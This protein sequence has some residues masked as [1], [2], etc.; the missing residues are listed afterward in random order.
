MKH[1][2]SL[3]HIILVLLLIVTF[4]QPAA[5]HTPVWDKRLVPSG[6][7][8]RGYNP[9]PLYRSSSTNSGVARLLFL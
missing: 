7:V 3:W 1:T 9:R 8:R 5:C 6:R 2:P 4:A